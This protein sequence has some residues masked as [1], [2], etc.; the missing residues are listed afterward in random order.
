MKKLLVLVLTVVVS[1]AVCCTGLA[2]NGR[3]HIEF[4]QS[5]SESVA[6]YDAVIAKFEEENPDIDI[7]QLNPPDTFTV[8]STRMAAHDA[9]DIFNHFPLRA[10]FSEV[11]NSDAI[12]PITG[13]SFLANINP[14]SVQM[15]T[16][17]D[18]EV[19]SLPLTMNTM[20][21]YYNNELFKK[22]GL[23]I[24]QTY[25]E[26]IQV[27]ETVKD[28][29][30]G[31]FLFACKDTWT[32]W[33][34]MDRRIGQLFMNTTGAE[35]FDQTFRKIGAGEMSAADSPEIVGA[36]QKC[37]DLFQYAQDDPFG[38]SFA[39]M[40]D[41][42]ANGKG[43]AFFQGTWAYPNIK[44]TNPDLDF[45]FCAFPA[46]EGQISYLS[47]N[48][49][50]GLS[51]SVDCENVDAAKKFLAFFSETENAQIFNDIDG[52]MSLVQGV[53]SNIPEFSDVF[54]IINAGKVYE[55]MSN[56]WPV[57]YNSTLMDYVSMM[58]MYNDLDT[59]I[60]DVDSMTAEFYAE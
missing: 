44:A 28:K 48:I 18:G 33:Q 26:L 25:Q 39:Q 54:E 6:A 58:L 36:A 49:D 42:F 51:L 15:C 19:Y 29:E 38:T 21:I 34:M 10:D 8:L 5:K 3:V 35:G 30:D 1:C 47:T 31:R 9:P 60:S 13:E 2:E 20:G 12:I 24:P 41:D 55:M 37:L 56:M 4:M 7:E 43:I 27:L 59:Y 46:D 50:I 45:S 57:N 32:L 22:Y 17:D 53:Q 52:S 16:R 40:C 11:V 14:E 23:E